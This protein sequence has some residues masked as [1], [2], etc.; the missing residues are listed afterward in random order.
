MKQDGKMMAAKAQSQTEGVGFVSHVERMKKSKKS[1]EK[2]RVI[3]AC[4]RNRRGKPL[5]ESLGEQRLPR[6]FIGCVIQCQVP[7]YR[8]GKK[9][10][11]MRR[12]S[13][14]FNYMANM[15]PKRLVQKKIQDF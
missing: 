11:S 5:T 12:N 4:G 6:F 7:V 8:D 2:K 13:F 15:P 14:A 10:P 9:T 3:F 1:K